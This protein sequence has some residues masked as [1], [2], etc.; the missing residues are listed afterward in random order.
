MLKREL[1]AKV[2]A[3]APGLSRADAEKVIDSVF[4][5]ITEALSSG[6]RVELR[7]FGAFS[8]RRRKARLG[9]NPRTQESVQVDEKCVAAFRAGKALRDRLNSK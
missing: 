3:E 8:V 6:G 5:A 7:G 4:D 9:R 1:A 2:A